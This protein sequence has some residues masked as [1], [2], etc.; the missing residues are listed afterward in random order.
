MTISEFRQLVTDVMGEYLP[1]IKSGDRADFLDALVDELID[2]DLQL[3]SDDPWEDAI[4]EKDLY[5]E[6]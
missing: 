5:T 3:E 4:P 6:D 2:A 1:K